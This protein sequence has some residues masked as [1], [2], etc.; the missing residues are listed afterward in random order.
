MTL[1]P[2]FG[3]G[4][5]VLTNLSSPNGV[6]EILTRYVV[7]RLRG[8]VPVN[9]CE[10]HRNLRQQFLAQAQITK[11]ARAKARHIGTNPAH[12]LAVYAGDY[13]NDAYGV[14]SIRVEGGALQWSW[15]GMGA[16]MAIGT[17]RS[18]NCLRPK[19][20]CC[21]ISFLSRFRL[22]AKAMSSV[23]RRHSS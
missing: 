2:D 4:V 7:D 6:T 3:L 15:R 5:A 20:D 17:M 16:I 1:V 12:N 21:Q 10:R 8:R 18:L 14:M 23:C 9:W 13:E 22:I 11:D 19:T